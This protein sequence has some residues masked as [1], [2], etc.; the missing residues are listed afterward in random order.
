MRRTEDT[1]GTARVGYPKRQGMSDR[2][3]KTPA[4]Y[5]PAVTKYSKASTSS[6]FELREGR[7]SCELAAL[8][9]TLY[10]LRALLYNVKECVEDRHGKTEKS[11]QNEECTRVFEIMRLGACQV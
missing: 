6:H 8:H 7:F 3:P 9:E 5:R 1:G 2:H 11:K 10:R 4:S